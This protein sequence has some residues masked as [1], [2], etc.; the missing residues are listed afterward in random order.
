MPTQ[1][2][3]TYADARGLEAVKILSDGGAFSLTVRDVTF[4]GPDLDRLEPLA[5]LPAGSPFTLGQGA[6]CACTLSWRMALQI[7]DG[8][9]TQPAMIRGALVLGEPAAGGRPSRSVELQLFYPGTELATAGP[10]ESFEAAL[11]DLQ[12]QL[13]PGVALAGLPRQRVV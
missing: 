10:H 11:A 1:W 7:T 4:A 8:R 12:E 3:A 13:A 9:L 5:E 2:R 6:L